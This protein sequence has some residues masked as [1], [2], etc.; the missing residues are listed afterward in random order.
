VMK[1]I[2][3]R[4]PIAQGTKITEETLAFKRSPPGLPP[5]EAAGIIGRFA[6]VDIDKDENITWDKV[7]E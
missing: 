5:S 7:K 3:A 1:N 6:R 4:M 2:V